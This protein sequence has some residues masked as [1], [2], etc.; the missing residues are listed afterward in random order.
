MEEN[1]KEKAIELFNTKYNCAQSIFI[2]YSDM[3]GIDKKTATKLTFGFGGGIAS[4][5][6]TCGTINAAVMLL[7][8]KYADENNDIERSK[9]V[10]NIIRNFMYDFQEQH[11]GINCVDLLT[12]EKGKVYSMHSEKCASI[13]SLVCDLLDKY[14]FM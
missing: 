6:K 5:G 14:L 2:A 7:S 4:T 10:K 11:K 8:L 12:E 9:K 13:V 3:F 1:R